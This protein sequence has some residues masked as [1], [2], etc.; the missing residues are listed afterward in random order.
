MTHR[1]STAAVQ[2]RALIHDSG[3]SFS[4]QIPSS[5]RKRRGLIS[6]APDPVGMQIAS[7][8]EEACVGHLSR[9]TAP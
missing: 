7:Y 5:A 8:D 2:F 6:F 4:A 3:H 1:G 9:R